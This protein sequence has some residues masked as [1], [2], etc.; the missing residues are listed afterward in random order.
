MKK[1]DL[2]WRQ[3]SVLAWGLLLWGGPVLLLGVVYERSLLSVAA[4]LDLPLE[5]WRAALAPAA[6]CA[7]W[8][9]VAAGA[10]CLFW[11][12]LTRVTGARWSDRLIPAWKWGT[13]YLCATG[14]VL[15]VW[16]FAAAYLGGHGH[17]PDKESL[18]AG[19]RTLGPI[20][21]VLS[22]VWILAVLLVRT[23]RTG[24]E[25]RARFLS[26]VGL[27]VLVPTMAWMTVLREGGWITSM[28]SLNGISDAAAAGLAW[29]LLSREARAD[30][31]RRPALLLLTAVLALGLY[32][33]YSRFLIVSYGGIPAETSFY[34]A[35]REGEWRV[36]LAVLAVLAIA[37]PLLAALAATVGRRVVVARLT[38][39]LVLAATVAWASW[40]VLPGISSSAGTCLTFMVI[41]LL[42]LAGPFLWNRQR[43]EQT[44]DAR[45][46]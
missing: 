37:L 38:A 26:A 31:V 7:G 46:D 2:L 13:A 19:V 5:A 9:A 1:N 40:N 35:R 12:M 39:L 21:L 28:A 42:P 10:G 25:K 24:L 34:T 20:A 6:A 15:A 8:W 44:M 18:L 41:S 16:A 17:P 43:R 45:K 29:A 22:V 11:W 30:A 36:V 14:W 23:G 3:I 33:A 27:I 32:F 4:R